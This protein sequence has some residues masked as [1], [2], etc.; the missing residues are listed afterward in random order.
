MD[1][2]SG[3]QQSGENLGVVGLSPPSSSLEGDEK[4]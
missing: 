1:I 3:S 4:M 2:A